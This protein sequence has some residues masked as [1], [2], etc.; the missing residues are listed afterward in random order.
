MR[1]VNRPKNDWIRPWDGKP[2]GIYDRD[3][4]FF[5]VVV[6]GALAW[7][8]NN[9]VLYGKPIRHFIFNTGSSYMYVE[10]NGY[11]Y[12]I[13]DVTDQDTIYM[14][15]PRCV[16]TLGGITIDTNELTQPYVRGTYE[17]LDSKDGQIKGYNAEIQRIPVDMRLDLSY[18]MSTFNEE[19]VLAQE[20]ID[21]LC[22]Q[23]YFSIVYLGQIIKCSLEFPADFQIE[24]NKV[25]MSSSEAN[26]K[27]LNIPL[28][29]ST[30]YP[31][32]NTASEEPNSI[33]MTKFRYELDTYYDE[34]PP[35]YDK[36]GKIVD[37]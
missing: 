7:L 23:R 1:T 36:Q 11:K 5:A 31:S 34:Y 13:T 24:L 32:I 27:L 12:S 18:V 35:L 20:L 3:D 10:T 25:D 22:F 14:E 4:R 33:L 37:S 29:L 17:R 19:I 9:I 26:N 15:R 6:K 21:K 2:D 30:S 16:A 28:T 8:T